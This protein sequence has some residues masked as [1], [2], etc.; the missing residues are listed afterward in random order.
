[1]RRRPFDCHIGGGNLDGGRDVA[2]ILEARLEAESEMEL[3]AYPAALL[4]RRDMW[5]LRCP[6]PK[7]SNS[8]NQGI[9]LDC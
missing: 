9:S 7:N 8:I 2:D 6:I 3:D 4:G 1:M 5:V